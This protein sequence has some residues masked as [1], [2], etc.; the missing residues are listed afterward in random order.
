[1]IRIKVKPS[2]EVSLRVE[3][4]KI[5]LSVSKAAIVS[6]ERDGYEG[7]YEVTPKVEAQTL[8]TANKFLRKDVS[9]F[10]IPFFDVGNESGGST[11]YIGTEVISDGN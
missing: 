8:P 3:R 11:I 9:V 7:S 2:N 10:A 4:D 1:M 5:G 6:G